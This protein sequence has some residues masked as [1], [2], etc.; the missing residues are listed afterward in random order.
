MTE[1]EKKEPKRISNVIGDDFKSWQA[2]EYYCIRSGTGTGKTH[3]IFYELARY[4][5]EQGKS[6]LYLCN[7]SKLKEDAEGYQRNAN[8]DNVK[9]MTYQQAE[10]IIKRANK[11]YFGLDVLKAYHDIPDLSGVNGSAVKFETVE[12]TD[13]FRNAYNELLSYDY[14]VADEYHYFLEDS[15]MNQDTFYSLWFIVRDSVQ[16]KILMSAT[17]DYIMSNVLWD[18]INLKGHNVYTVEK[19]NSY[20]DLHFYNDSKSKGYNFAKDKLEWILEYTDSKAIYFVDTID[21]MK[22]LLE[23]SELIRSE[24]HCLLSSSR[25]ESDILNEPDCIQEITK[26]LITFS[27]RILLT[28]SVLSTGVTLKDRDINYI[29]CDLKDIDTVIQC[30]GRKRNLDE[31]D[32][33]EVYV[34]YMTNSEVM[35]R[36]AK[37]AEQYQLGELFVNNREVYASEIGDLGKKHAD[38]VF[39]NWLRDGGTVE[40]NSAIHA[41][42]CRQNQLLTEMSVIAATRGSEFFEDDSYGYTHVFVKETGLRPKTGEW[43]IQYY[44]DSE[45]YLTKICDIVMQNLDKKILVKS[46]A[47]REIEKL[48]KAMKLERD[49]L[50]HRISER[51]D[52]TFEF[53]TA[54]TTD[55]NDPMNGKKYLKFTKIEPKTI[56]FTDDDAF[57]EYMNQFN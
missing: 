28:T 34:K 30:I 56:K 22:S 48:R 53:K 11:H 15:G 41:Y 5:K 39:I 4:A 20:I 18:T 7:R 2:G 57:I 8:V 31:N 43:V 51:L 6:I 10:E 46:D 19:D 25:D 17:G 27:K 12:E 44:G 35:K 40:L 36:R 29:I 23:E 37:A 13:Y 50:F 52:C 9:I 1:D 24:A 14:I 33:C 55:R 32:T 47:F 54:W 42:Y 38:A 26:E 49:E 45:E 16:I 21:T 3:F